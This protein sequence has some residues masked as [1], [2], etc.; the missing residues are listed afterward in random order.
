V[1]EL[2]V[3]IDPL[4]PEST[5]SLCHKRGALATALWNAPRRS[6][7]LLHCHKCKLGTV[8]T[9]AEGPEL[10]GAVGAVRA[11]Q[12]DCSAASF[13]APAAS[14]ASNVRPQCPSCRVKPQVPL[15]IQQNLLAFLTWTGSVP[16]HCNKRMQQA[17]GRPRTQLV[18][19][20]RPGCMLVP[21]CRPVRVNGLLQL[22]H[23][24]VNVLPPTRAI[25]R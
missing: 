4:Q 19:Q 21:T 13:T 18:G 12:N 16:H 17:N 14:I 10:T 22:C 7:T 20:S 1:T 3:M 9:H 25:P 24:P 23:C 2:A 8:V 6:P 5:T 11:T 15:V